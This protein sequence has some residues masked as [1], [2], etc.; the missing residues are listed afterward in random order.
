MHEENLFGVSEGIIFRLRNQ[1]L[2]TTNGHGRLEQVPTGIKGDGDG[3]LCV[4]TV[5]EI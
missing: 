3:Y 2:T 1:L 4:D 5:Q